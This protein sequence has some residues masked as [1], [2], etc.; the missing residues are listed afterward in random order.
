MVDLTQDLARARDS[1]GVAGVAVRHLSDLYGAQAAVFLSDGL[2]GLDLLAEQDASF[3]FRTD[4]MSVARWAFHHRQPAGLD[5]DTLPGSDALY[6]PME[7]SGDILGVVGIRPQKH[8]GESSFEDRHRMEAVVSQTALAM[9]RALLAERARKAQMEAESE[10]LRSALLSS[11]S[12][13]FRT[14]LA[15]IVGASSAMA[16]GELKSEE[17]R[18]LAQSVYEESLR[19]S[20]FVANLL[21]MTRL[22]SGSVDLKRELQPIEEV[23]G[24][25]L[26]RVKPRLGTREVV[27]D[28]P[29]SLPVVAIDARLMEQLFVNLLE[30][31]ARHTPDGTRVDIRATAEGG[32]LRVT[33]EDRGP[34]LPPGSESRVFEKFF[35]ASDR[36]EGAGLGLAICH[37]IAAA[38]GG[39]ITASNRP[40]GGASFVVTLVADALP[41]EPSGS[42]TTPE[43][44]GGGP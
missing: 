9:E 18:E 40:G 43:A 31:V 29:E 10:R 5:T 23:V 2:E 15:S 21:D 26:E 28:L 12:H 19:L 34:G 11:V 16:S 32:L 30:N 37:A 24:P 22:E 36:V 4:E 20:R 38:H 41:G 1:K 33:V 25:A 27:V 14:P 13:D 3:A 35:R 44:Q 8:P 7:A 6:L 17:I 42:G 39:T